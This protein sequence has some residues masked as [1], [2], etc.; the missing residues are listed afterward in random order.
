MWS[1]NFHCYF[2][3]VF[4]WIILIYCN[5]GQPCSVWLV[6]VGSCACSI[7]N[8]REQHHFLLRHKKTS[9]HRIINK[10]TTQICGWSIKGRSTYV[11][12]WRR[13]LTITLTLE[14]YY[15]VPSF[16]SFRSAVY[17]PVHRTPTHIHT[18]THTVFENTY[19]MFF[20]FRFQKNMTFYVFLKWRIKKS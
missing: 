1:L 19:F 11:R 18:Y 15:T 16:K 17:T 10:Q 12:N 3:A 8:R 7:Y 14:D 9:S 20:F 5:V 6:N 2:S 13:L 4:S